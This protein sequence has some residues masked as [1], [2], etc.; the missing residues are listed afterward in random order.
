[1]RF[2]WKQRTDLNFGGL[3]EVIQKEEEEEKRNALRLKTYQKR[4]K[5]ENVSFSG[6]W[7][8][9]RRMPTWYY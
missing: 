5:K 8:G 9:P 6:E 2:Q 7:G 3:R 1:M 4:K